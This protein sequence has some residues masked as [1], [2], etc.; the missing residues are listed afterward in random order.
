MHEAPAPQRGQDGRCHGHDVLGL[1]RIDNREMRAG[2]GR[3]PMLA[4][5]ENRGR[6]GGDGLE[7]RSPRVRIVRPAHNRREPRR[8]Q[9]VPVS[10]GREGVTNIVIGDGDA[11]PGGPCALDRGETACTRIAVTRKVKIGRR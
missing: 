3:R 8:L 5:A 4:E 7:K 11:N 6:F 1:D 9:Q 2:S 10:E